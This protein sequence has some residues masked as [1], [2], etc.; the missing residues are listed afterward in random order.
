MGALEITFEPTIRYALDISKHTSIGLM[1]RPLM[2]SQAPRDRALL[3]N[4]RVRVA[5]QV[6]QHGGQPRVQQAQSQP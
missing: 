4:G 2:M 6:I 1:R 5:V 3:T